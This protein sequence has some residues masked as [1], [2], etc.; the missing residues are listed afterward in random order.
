MSGI[1]FKVNSNSNKSGTKKSFLTKSNYIKVKHLDNSF[2]FYAHLQHNGVLV[3][4]NQILQEGQITGLSDCTGFCDDPHLHFEVYLEAKN[5][6]NR[7]S[8]PIEFITKAGIVKQVERQKNYR[9]VKN[10]KPCR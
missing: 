7:K 8:V 10:T 4:E 9:V 5:K 1:V 6:F 2:S 3:K